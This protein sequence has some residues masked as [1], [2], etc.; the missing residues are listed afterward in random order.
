MCASLTTKKFVGAFI[1][2]NMR[3]RNSD[4]GE[5]EN[6]VYI[7]RR[8]FSWQNQKIEAE[9]PQNKWECD[10]PDMHKKG[11]FSDEHTFAYVVAWVHF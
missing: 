9:E 3:R 11:P 2:E 4:F 8:I 10:I 5:R 7:H 6:F 1:I